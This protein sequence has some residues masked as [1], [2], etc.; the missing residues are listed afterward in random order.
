MEKAMIH[1][2]KC[3]Y[4]YVTWDKK[5]PR[6]CKLFGFKSAGMPATTVFEATGS[7]CANYEEKHKSE[8]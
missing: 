8:K 7:H 5:F 3:K 4:F 6:G 1:C 2:C